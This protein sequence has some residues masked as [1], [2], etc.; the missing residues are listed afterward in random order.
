MAII[1]ANTY[2][3]Y[4]GDKSFDALKTFLK[5]NTYSNYYILCDENSFN[6]CLSNLLVNAPILNTAEIIELESGE[7]NKTLETCMQVWGAL[8]DTGA[9]KKSLIV[10][11]GGGVISDLG[12]F[13][14]ATFKRGIDCINIPTTL[15]SMVDAS[16][17]GKTGVDFEGIKNHIGTT[18]EP[19]GIFVNPDFLKTLSARHIKNGYAEIIKIA[20]IAD[21]DFWKELKKLTSVE[22][23]SSEKIITKAIALKNTIVKKDLHEKGL[24]KSLNFG[25][26]IGHALE[27]ALIQ[28][29][30]D[31]LHGE[32]IIYGMIIETE[33]AHLLKQITKAEATSINNYLNKIYKK[34]KITKATKDLLLKYVLHDKKNEAGSLCFSLPKGIGNYQLYEN[35]SID[36]IKKIL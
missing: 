4:V 25:H 14:A 32:A 6:Y 28:Q 3:I 12:G 35:I 18:S 16:V 24:R 15:L 36:L 13:V 26:T 9:D 21:V 19:K 34:I 11:L 17:G 1:K 22:E 2:S 7:E 33:I 23:F 31:I 29:K 30:K 27:S 5:Y 8:T 10:N 20:L